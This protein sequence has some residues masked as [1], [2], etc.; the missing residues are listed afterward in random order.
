MLRYAADGR[1]Q[2]KARVQIPLSPGPS[3]DGCLCQAIAA[4][5]LCLPRTGTVQCCVGR[6]EG[7]RTELSTLRLSAVRDRRDHLLAMRQLPDLLRWRVRADPTA[8]GAASSGGALPAQPPRRAAPCGPTTRL[9]RTTCTTR[10]FDSDAYPLFKRC[11]GTHSAGGRADH[12]EG[13]RRCS[14]CRRSATAGSAR[15]G[16]A[17]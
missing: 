8:G 13:A 15:S 17:R 5:P 4:D 1:Q 7:A 2:T 14:R 9:A 12:G 11:G 10:M 16:R 6:R 3:V